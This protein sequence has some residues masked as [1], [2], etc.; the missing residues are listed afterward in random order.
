MTKAY[1]LANYD[2]L[3]R[4]S[5]LTEVAL[6]CLA[7]GEFSFGPWVSV[8]GRR[9]CRYRVGVARIDSAFP[10]A[11]VSFRHPGQSDT[12]RPWELDKLADS[13]RRYP[14]VEDAAMQESYRVAM[15]KTR[16]VSA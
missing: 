12:N 9:E 16:K 13:W 4:E 15:D 10:V 5:S 8:A 1:K 7:N 2:A 3:Y 14:G 11:L 6:T